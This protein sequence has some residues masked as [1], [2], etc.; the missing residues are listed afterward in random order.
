MDLKLAKK[1]ALVTGSTAGK[2]AI[3]RDQR[4]RAAG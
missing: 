3:L 2:P 4:R 1:I